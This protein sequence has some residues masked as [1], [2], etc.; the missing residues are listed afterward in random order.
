MKNIN[1][2]TPKI[3]R[4]ISANNMKEIFFC[5][6]CNIEFIPS[7]GRIKEAEKR[8]STVKYCS[9]KCYDKTGVKNP[10]WRGGK[11]LVD[12]YFYIQQPEH[13]NAT[14]DGYVCEHRLVMEKKL[15]R[16][17]LLTEVVHHRD[18][19]KTNNIINNLELVSSTGRHFIDHH[20]KT[21]DAL[22]KFLEAK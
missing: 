9:M 5:K 15:G 8:D 10:K 13:P 3:V 22:G 19:N 20:L 21:R 7:T 1:N 12:G 16:L 17:L 11:I 18:H 2:V 6:T 14:K 4:I